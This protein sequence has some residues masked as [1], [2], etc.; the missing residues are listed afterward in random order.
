MSAGPDFTGDRAAGPAEALFISDL[1]LSEDEPDTVAAFLAFAEG[2][3]RSARALYILG[4]LFEYWAGD[5]DA[6]DP[7]HQRVAAA[8]RALTD[9]GTAVYFI[10]GNRDFLIG[11]D[12]AAQAGMTLLPDPSLIEF[13]G[14]R[15]LL[16]HGDT[17]CTDDLA[18]QDFRRQ[19]RN[20]AWQKAFL[21][22]PL[23]ERRHMVE[24]VR[25]QSRAANKQKSAEIMDVN[26]AAVAALLREHG[27]PLLIHGHTHRPAQHR[28]EVDGHG[29]ER[30]VLSAWHGHAPYLRWTGG[31]LEA[32]DAS[33]WSI[34]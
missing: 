7:L 23:A 26:D 25:A 9:A 22:M 20:E 2:P 3:A 6:E 18:Y 33:D 21:E 17:L 24:V 34:G 12:Y 32:L 16:C 11:S 29:C 14:R 10:A 5:D 27:Y 30:W 4:D 13:D 28:H 31:R 19:V 15:I 1:H 8:L